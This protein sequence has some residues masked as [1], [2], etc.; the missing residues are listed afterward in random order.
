MTRSTAYMSPS[1]VTLTVESRPFTI[2]AKEI[3]LPPMAAN[4]SGAGLPDINLESVVVGRGAL[5]RDD[6][7]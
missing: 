3:E 5:T 1:T 4:G 6:G 7:S 2:S